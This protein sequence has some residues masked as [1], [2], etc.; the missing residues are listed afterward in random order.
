MENDGHPS[1]SKEVNVKQILPE[2]NEDTTTIP[3]ILPGFKTFEEFRQAGFKTL[4]EATRNSTNLPSGHNWDYYTSFPSFKKVMDAEGT[5][6]LELISMLLHHQGVKGNILRRDF[7]EKFDLIIDAN[8]HILERV[9][10]STREIA[11]EVGRSHSDVW[12]CKRFQDTGNTEDRP[13]SGRPRSTRAHE[14]CYLVLMVREEPTAECNRTLPTAFRCY[15]KVHFYTDNKKPSSSCKFALKMYLEDTEDNSCTMACEGDWIHHTPE[16][17]KLWPER[18][19][20]PADDR[21]IVRKSKLNPKLT[22][23]DLTRELMAT[24]GANIHVTTVRHRLLE[25]GRRARKPIKKQL[26]TPVMCKNA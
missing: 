13:R 9:G 16:K 26:L 14:D 10:R 25:A 11:L 3:D 23:V 17:R 20:S 12:A 6:V 19:T 8:D 1:T 4:M 24:T 7:E 18:K 15:W 21:L 2:N 22:A 5:R